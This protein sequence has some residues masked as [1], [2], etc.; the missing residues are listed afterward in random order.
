MI[1]GIHAAEFFTDLTTAGF[2]MN[3][4]LLLITPVH[5]YISLYRTTFINAAKFLL[6]VK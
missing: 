5:C 1:N 6:G 4:F 3:T 2:K